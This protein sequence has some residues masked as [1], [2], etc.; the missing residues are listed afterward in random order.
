MQFHDTIS[1]ATHLFT[2]AWAAFAILLLLRL[3]RNHG[4]A[5]WSVAIYGATLVLLYLASGTFH[6]LLVLS[7]DPDPARRAEAVRAMWMFQRLDKSAIFLLIAGSYTPVFVYMISGKLRWAALAVE[8]GIAFVGIVLMWTYPSMPHPLLVSLYVGMGVGGLVLVPAV[9]TEVGVR[10]CIWI[11]GI[12]FFYVGGAAVDVFQWPMLIP[13]W[14]GP[15]EILHVAD[16]AGTLCHFGFLVKFV[17]PLGPIDQRTPATPV[18]PDSFP[19]S[20]STMAA[21]SQA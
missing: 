1:S 7:A 19:E 15:H 21:G 20:L 13:G 5:R 9:V 11:A 4:P 2:A 16:I 17:I 3:T 14:I 10:G 8:W 6:G 12:A 18:E